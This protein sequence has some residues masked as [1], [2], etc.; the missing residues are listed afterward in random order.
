MMPPHTSVVYSS[1]EA[2]NRPCSGVVATCGLSG[3][4]IH[5]E[6][7]KRNVELRLAMQLLV[8]P[9][10]VAKHL[11]QRHLVLAGRRNGSRRL[12]PPW[13]AGDVELGHGPLGQLDAGIRDCHVAAIVRHSV[14]LVEVKEANGDVELHRGRP[15]VEPPY[16][17]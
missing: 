5:I 12:H 16:V 2:A 3:G 11:R 7:A 10:M 1:L 6:K 17:R 4:D 14:I 13:P 8:H 15:R 9:Y